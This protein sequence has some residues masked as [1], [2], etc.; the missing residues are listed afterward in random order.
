[1]QFQHVLIGMDFSD[2]AIAAAQ[3]AAA[4]FAPSA[5]M[6]LAHSIEPPPR[7]RFAVSA[8]PPAEAIEG[9]AREFAERRMREIAAFLT[10]GQPEHVVRVGKADETMITLAT[11]LAADL[12]VIGPHGDR[13]RPHK[14]LGTTAERIVHH[15]PVPVLVATTPPARAPRN[16]LVPV[17]DASVTPSLLGTTRDLAEAFEASVT[18]LHVWSNAVYSHV[19]SMSYAAHRDEDEARRE[20]DQELHDASVHWLHEMAR[21]G[22]CR[23]P[24]H[25]HVAYGKAGDETL[26]YADEIGADLIVIGRHGAGLVRPTVL[27]TTVNTVLHGAHCPVLVVVEPRT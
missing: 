6:T 20:I 13:P 9:V 25:A 8:L 15:A 10:P 5:R 3:W 21:A 4:H 17:D 23:A 12:I 2:T 16:I 26:K 19:A 22:G 27:G 1:M 18:L 7:P 11:E 24:V 14:F